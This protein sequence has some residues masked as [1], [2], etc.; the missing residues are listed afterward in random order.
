MEI[1]SSYVNQPDNTLLFEKCSQWIVWSVDIQRTTI[2]QLA[3]A[4]YF[5]DEVYFKQKTNIF[6]N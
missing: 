4:I 1:V 2:H 6:F 5:R 3:L